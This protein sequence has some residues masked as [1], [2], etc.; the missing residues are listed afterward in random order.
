MP[1]RAD[2]SGSSFEPITAHVPAHAATTSPMRAA[3]ASLTGADRAEQAV[4]DGLLAGHDPGAF[5][6][7]SRQ[8]ASTSS[9]A[10][11]RVYTCLSPRLA[12]EQRH[13]V[14]QRRALGVGVDPVVGPDVHHAVVG[15]HVQDRP[16]GSAG[17]DLLRQPVHVRELVDPGG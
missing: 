6:E 1:Y 13:P 14:A 10:P 8:V 4:L 11:G 16:V 17:G 3:M 7:T 5:A 9:A 2:S 15:R 12:A